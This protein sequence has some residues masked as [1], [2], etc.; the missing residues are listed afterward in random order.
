MIDNGWQVTVTVAASQRATK[1]LTKNVLM[2]S[3]FWDRILIGRLWDPAAAAAAA[4]RIVSTA[5]F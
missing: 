5:D 1:T 2:I 4:D 3:E